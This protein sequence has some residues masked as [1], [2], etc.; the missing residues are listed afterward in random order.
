MTESQLQRIEAHLDL[1][2]LWAID[3]SLPNGIYERMQVLQGVYQELTGRPG[4]LSCSACIGEL[5]DTLY[6]EYEKNRAR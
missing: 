3:R 6:N 1:I 5:L 4:N 2:K